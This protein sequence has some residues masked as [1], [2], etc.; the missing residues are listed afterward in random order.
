MEVWL[1]EGDSNSKCF[2]TSVLARRVENKIEEV[3]IVD[4]FL[5]RGLMDVGKEMVDFFKHLL[6]EQV[7][8]EVSNC[9]L[10]LLR[11]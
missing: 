8:Q 10:D 2:P 3:K 1:R 6:E 4:D 11:K 5:A 7:S 9:F